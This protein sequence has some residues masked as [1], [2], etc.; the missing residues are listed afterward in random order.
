MTVYIGG[1]GGGMEHVGATI[2]SLSAL[3]HEITHSWFARGVMP[4]DGNSGWFD[5]SIASWRD[6]GYPSY[7]ANLSGDSS[8]LAG[9]S[10]YRRSTPDASYSAG[11]RLMGRLDSLF[12]GLKPVLKEVFSQAKRTTVNT[13]AIQDLLESIS[14]KDVDDYF[15]RYVFAKSRVL[16]LSHFGLAPEW[17]KVSAFTLHPRP[18]TQK[19]IEDL[20]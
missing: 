6:N 4:A 1:G 3:G 13:K 5:E 10:A 15:Q 16:D 20:R 9:F 7:A 8:N 19:D 12:G 17:S 2:T 18:L 11:M 14:Q